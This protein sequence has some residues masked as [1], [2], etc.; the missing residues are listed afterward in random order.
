MQFKNMEITIMFGVL[1][2]AN[3]LTA[4]AVL[5]STASMILIA[6]GCFKSKVHKKLFSQS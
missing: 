3:V 5:L 6:V 2:I 4:F 1:F